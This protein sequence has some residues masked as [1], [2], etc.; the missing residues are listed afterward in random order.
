M[1]GEFLRKKIHTSTCSV[2]P[3]PDNDVLSPTPQILTGDEVPSPIT[4]IVSNIEVPSSI[5]QI[6]S[7]VTPKVPQKVKAT[8]R[9]REYLTK[10]RKV[11]KKDKE[12]LQKKTV[13]DKAIVDMNRGKFESL[14]KRAAYHN[15]LVSTLH[16]L[17]C[18]GDQF[19]GSGKTLH[20]LSLDEEAVILRHVK[21]TLGSYSHLCKKVSLP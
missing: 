6:V 1:E 9:P 11:I 12:K 17:F 14:R 16:R 10:Y 18:N 8:N 2:T 5:P 13:F 19:K 21:W 15:V 7:E 20:C 3:A 4:P